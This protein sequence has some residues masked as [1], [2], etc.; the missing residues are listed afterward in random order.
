MVKLVIGQARTPA[1]LHYSSTR[2]DGFRP[3]TRRKSYRKKPARFANSSKR[4]N[5][6][7]KL[8]KQLSEFAETKLLP[9]DPMQEVIPTPIQ[10]GA[11]CYYKGF[12]MGEDRP[13]GWDNEIVPLKGINTTLGV[14]STQRVGNYIYYK[15]THLCFQVDMNFVTSP[16]APV[17]LRCVIV[18]ARQSVMPA[19]LTDPPQSTLFLNQAGSPIGYQN[20]GITGMDVLNN[21]LNKRDWVVA[22]DFKFTLTH[23]CRSDSDGGNVG[24][25]GKYPS[26]KTFHCN[27]GYWKKTRINSTSNLPEDLDTRYL[28]FFFASAIGKDMGADGWEV[29]ARGTT[30][31]NDV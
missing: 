19:G 6:N 15:K 27:L 3:K 8:A 7:R 25:S 5:R 1:R 4:Y 10:T 12:I 28:V 11:I 9:T 13:S 24:Y 20:G 14:S 31:Y 26:R 29:S 30:S 17:E 18:K 21:P 16:R 23:P 22:K 2:S